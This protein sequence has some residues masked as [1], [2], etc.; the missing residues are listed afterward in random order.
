M[1]ENSR[2]VLALTSIKFIKWNEMFVFVLV[3][4]H[5]ADLKIINHFWCCVH[6]SSLSCPFPVSQLES[7]KRFRRILPYIAVK[8][9]GDTLILM[10]WIFEPHFNYKP[11]A[12]TYQFP[13]VLIACSVI[14]ESALRQ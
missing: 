13:V 1:T 12:L 6:S 3:V 4:I 7:Q 10:M 11:P 5:D 8:S 2:L 9:D 14:Y